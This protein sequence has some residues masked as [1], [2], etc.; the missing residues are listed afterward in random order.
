MLGSALW[1]LLRATKNDIKAG[2]EITLHCFSVNYLKNL[3]GEFLAGRSRHDIEEKWDLVDTMNL[4]IIERDFLKATLQLM[5][6]NTFHGIQFDA[7]NPFDSGRKRLDRNFGLE[8]G[9]QDIHAKDLVVLPDT[10]QS[11]HTFILKFTGTIALLALW[12]TN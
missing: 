6:N 1:H 10:Y 9:S 3:L 12:Q 4:E 2:L 5:M 8:Y 11:H 7:Y